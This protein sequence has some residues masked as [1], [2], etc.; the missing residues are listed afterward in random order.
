MSGSSH[1][2]LVAFHV[3][4]SATD[5]KFSRAQAMEHMYSAIAHDEYSGPGELSYWIAEDD[6][7][8]GSD[9]DSA[10]FCNPGNQEQ[11][12][13]VLYN[14]VAMRDGKVV[15]GDDLNRLTQKCNLVTRTVRGQFDGSPV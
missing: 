1:V 7:I 2:I 9:C 14:T 13:R 15:E 12:S 4:A 6:R 5:A 8:D 11:A 10:V 3:D